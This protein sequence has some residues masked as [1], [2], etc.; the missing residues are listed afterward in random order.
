MKS[1]CAGALLVAVFALDLSAQ[2]A[3][4]RAEVSLGFGR[5]YHS[6][7]AVFG[8]AILTPIGTGAR[9]VALARPCRAV[10][11]RGGR[12]YGATPLP[13]RW[14]GTVFGTTAGARRNLRC[15]GGK[16][17]LHSCVGER[18]S[19]CG[20]SDPVPSEDITGTHRNGWS[21]GPQAGWWIRLSPTTSLAVMGFVEDQS[22]YSNA[23]TRRVWGLALHAA[24]GL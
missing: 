24:F 11:A 21:I 22:I 13:P 7:G 18:H 5:I 12:L 23:S 4:V 1:A 2:S 10:R 9:R 6:T 16:R 3:S 19:H 14:W 15:S 8:G 17:A 20:P